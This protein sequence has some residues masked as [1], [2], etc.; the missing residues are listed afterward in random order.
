MK[1]ELVNLYNINENII[2]CG[3]PH[4]DIHN[5]KKSDQQIKKFVKDLNLDPKI[6]YLI[7][8][9][10]SPYFASLEIEIVEN[11]ANYI[12]KEEQLNLQ[13]IIRPHPQNVK[14]Y[15]SDKSWL[16]RLKK[17]ENLKKTSVF[18]PLLADGDIPW[19]MNFSDLDTLST[20]IQGSYAVLNTCSTFAIDGMLNDKP[21]IMTPFDSNKILN[22]W[23]SSRKTT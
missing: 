7:F 1:D 10:S 19:Q 9:M 4:F 13:M 12:E 16:P 8:G 22:Y 15:L 6:P 2:S 18:Y 3:V 20:A 23:L 14:G 5:N 11:I 21:V 17:L